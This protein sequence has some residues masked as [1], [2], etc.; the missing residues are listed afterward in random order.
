MEKG[1]LD[2]ELDRMSAIAG[3][4]S[5]RLPAAVQ[6]VVRVHER[7]RRL[8]DRPPGHPR[9]DRG[10]H[11]DHLRHPPVRPGGTLS[12]P[13]MTRRRCSSAPNGSPTASRT[14]RL[15]PGEPLPTSYGEDL[16]QQVFGTADRPARV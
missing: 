13:S 8:R 6:R 15:P 12:T 1:K 16:Y 11:P 14:F 5:A 10:G 2:E 7:A 9:A 3:Q 4:I